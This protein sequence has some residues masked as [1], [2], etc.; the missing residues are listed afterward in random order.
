MN[1]KFGNFG[2]SGGPTFSKCKLLESMED[3]RKLCSRPSDVSIDYRCLKLEREVYF[4]P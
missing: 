2:A 3:V 4:T 1:F